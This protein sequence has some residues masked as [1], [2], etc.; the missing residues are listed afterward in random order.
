MID[1]S[2]PLANGIVVK[3]NIVAFSKSCFSQWYGAY[4][5]QKHP[6][7]IRSFYFKSFHPFSTD[8]KEGFD[9]TCLTSKISFN[10]A[11]QAMMYAKAC[12]FKDLDTAEKILKETNPRFQKD[13]GR[14][15]KNYDDVIW[16]KKRF[17]IIKM[18]N[19]YKFSQ[20]E[21]LKEFLLSTGDHIICEASPWDKIWGIGLSTTDSRTF[22]VETW[23]G[24]N[25]LGRVLMSV[26][27]TLRND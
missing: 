6:L 12:L 20:N 3:N 22:N 23:E 14:L 16:N 13:L 7:I 18:I 9:P 10:C 11:E 4:K 1:L 21:A 15:V 17:E 26:R 2:S 25:L 8:P 5:G 27:E 19:Y 24:R